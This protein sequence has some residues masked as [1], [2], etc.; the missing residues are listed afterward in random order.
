MCDLRILATCRVFANPV[1]YKL[2]GRKRE[3]ERTGE[4]KTESEREREG[5]REN[6]AFHMY[7]VLSAYTIDSCVCMHVVLI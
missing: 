4:R 3:T 7:S 6:V 2:V 1:T 5:E